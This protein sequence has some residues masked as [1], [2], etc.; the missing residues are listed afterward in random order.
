MEILN[1]ASDDQIALMGCAAAI[2]IC[3]GMMY[4]S[5]FVGRQGKNEETTGRS[6]PM[7]PARK[8]DSDSPER[9]AA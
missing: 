7:T 9:K 5:F 2:L 1:N 6:I 3:G 4:L 8:V